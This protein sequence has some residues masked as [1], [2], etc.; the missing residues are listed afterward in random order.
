M[1]DSGATPEEAAR[2]WV[3]SREPKEGDQ[4]VALLASREVEFSYPFGADHVVWIRIGSELVRVQLER[5]P[6]GHW[7][8]LQNP[9]PY[10]S[11]REP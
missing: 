6:G 8:A 5:R 7:S 11:P 3:I 4:V 10:T 1:S 9:R 2:E